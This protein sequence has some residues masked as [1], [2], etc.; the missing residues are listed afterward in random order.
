MCLSITQFYGFYYYTI[1]IKL[2]YFNSIKIS[3]L[4]HYNLSYSRNSLDMWQSSRPIRKYYAVQRTRNVS[5]TTIYCCSG[6]KISHSSPRECIKGTLTSRVTFIFMKFSIA[7]Y[8]KIS[9]MN[10]F[11]SSDLLSGLWFQ[12]RLLC[13]TKQVPM[14][15]GMGWVCLWRW[16]SVFTE[17][18]CPVIINVFLV[19]FPV[20]F[21]GAY[22]FDKP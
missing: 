15:S 20:L 3:S 11:A 14:F 18:A 7:A 6:W 10:Y 13:R 8:F 16:Y 4:F 2:N 22:H 1:S 21:M 12:S 17:H 19:I 5:V 9:P